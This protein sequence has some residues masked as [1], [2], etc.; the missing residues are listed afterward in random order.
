VA[1]DFP[2]PLERLRPLL[3]LLARQLRLDPALRC[4]LDESDLAQEALLRAHDRREQFRGTTEAEMVAWV[5]EILAHVAADALRRETAQ[6]RDPAREVR[7]S[8]LRWDALLADPGE[9]PSE[10]AR[11]RERLEALAAALEQLP[12]PER[13]AVTAKDLMGL[14]VAEVAERLGRTHQAAVGLLRRGR[15]RLRALLSEQGVHSDDR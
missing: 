9:S 6:G 8:S 14:S 4:R 7:D 10:A 15:A 12:Q 13:D 5:K 1:D 2:M 3:R 11:R